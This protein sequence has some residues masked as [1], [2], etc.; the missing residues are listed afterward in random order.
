MTSK[1]M[2]G[3]NFN[4]LQ[5]EGFGEVVDPA[6]LKIEMVDIEAEV[7]KLRIRLN[8]TADIREK[9]IFQ[10]KIDKLLLKRYEVQQLLSK[11][12]AY[13]EDIAIQLID[14]DAQVEKLKVRV[15]NIQDPGERKLYLDEIEK[16]NHKREAVRDIINKSRMENNRTDNS[17]KGNLEKAWNDLK[18]SLHNVSTRFKY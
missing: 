9:T 7:A 14:L 1:R 16:L 10:D 11:N 3:N 5:K 8:S 15:K 13:H 6:A 12:A 17:L 4:T 18:V 2:T